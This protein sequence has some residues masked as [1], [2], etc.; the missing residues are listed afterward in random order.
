MKS[1]DE[2]KDFSE[3]EC[4]FCQGIDINMKTYQYDSVE[5]LEILYI[6]LHC[7]KNGGL[8]INYVVLRQIHRRCEYSYYINK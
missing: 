3:H 5:Y 8:N 4:P 6:C 2:Y 1:L 7:Y